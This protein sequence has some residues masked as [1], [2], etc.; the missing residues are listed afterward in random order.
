MDMVQE[1]RH[2]PG[3]LELQLDQRLLYVRFQDYLVAYD[4]ESAYR[5]LQ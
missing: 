5:R 1:C 3:G 4:I 2:E